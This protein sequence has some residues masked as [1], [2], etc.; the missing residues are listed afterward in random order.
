MDQRLA[1]KPPFSKQVRTLE[2]HQL[3]LEVEP[4]S[5]QEAANRIE[6]QHA[7]GLCGKSQLAQQKVV[8][9]TSSGGEIKQQAVEALRSHWASLRHKVQWH[10]EDD[11]RRCADDISLTLGPVFPRLTH[12][13]VGQSRPSL[14][15]FKG[16]LRSIRGGFW[17][18]W[19]AKT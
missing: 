19:M 9:F 18:G 13:H 15:V 2:I 4:V 7:A 12:D 6:E 10:S 5:R 14:E 16:A 11:L 8:V 17:D 1:G 3:E